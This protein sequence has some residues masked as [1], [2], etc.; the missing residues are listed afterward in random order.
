MRKQWQMIWCLTGMASLCWLAQDAMGQW[1]VDPAAPQYPQYVQ[2]PQ[3]AP[4]V[5]PAVSGVQVALD[6]GQ[7]DQLLGPIALYPDPLLSLIFP[8]ATYP[9]DIV[10]AAQ[11]LAAT[12]NPT[13]ADIDAQN[14]DGAV[15]GLAHYPSVLGMMN[16][17]I[18]WTQTVGAAYLNQ[19][20]DVLASVQRLRAQAQAAKNLQTTPQEQVLSDQGAIYIEP[21]D[22]NM[23][24]VPTYDPNLVYDNPYQITFGDGYPIGLWLNNDFDWNNGYIED[25]GGWYHGWHH[26]DAWDRNPPAWNHNGA[27]WLAAPKQWGRAAR[28]TAPRVTAATA[29]RIGVDRPGGMAPG[30]RNSAPARGRIGNA[31]AAQPSRSA[32]EPAGSRSDAQRAVQRTQPQAAQP[33]AAVPQAAPQRPAPAHANPAPRSQAPAPQAPARSS[34]FSGGS[35]GAARAQSSRGN[36]SSGS[37]R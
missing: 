22:P 35:G 20:K 2:Y 18:N 21:A 29:A 30:A 19:Q 10:A 7:L 36:A 27:G 6:A 25:G 37:R 16:A 12:P 23:M 33:R 13:Q 32:F 31:P 4:P 34:A 17:Q 11:W 8:G 14:W 24:Y 3:G 9:Q 1:Q 15:K 5:M 26:P 28:G